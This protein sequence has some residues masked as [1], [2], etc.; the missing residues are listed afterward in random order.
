MQKSHETVGISL[1]TDTALPFY[2]YHSKPV[3][4]LALINNKKSDKIKMFCNKFQLV[5]FQRRRI[6]WH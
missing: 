1:H 6:T 2:M 3:N 4:Q 5:V